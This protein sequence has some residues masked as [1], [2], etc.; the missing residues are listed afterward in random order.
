[1]QNM[2]QSLWFCW[3]YIGYPSAIS[4]LRYFPNCKAKNL[5]RVLTLENL[6][7]ESGEIL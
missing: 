6:T 5:A 4:V 1:M 3:R 2:L 7:L